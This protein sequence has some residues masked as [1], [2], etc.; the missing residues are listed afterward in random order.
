MGALEQLSQS[1][2]EKVSKTSAQSFPNNH[3]QV[4]EVLNV[5]LATEIVCALRYKNHYYRAKQLGSVDAAD[6]FL[7]HSNQESEHANQLADRIAQLGV[8]PNMDPEYIVRNK[9]SE[10]R[11][12][13]TVLEMIQEN[14]AAEHL[15][16]ETYR[17]LIQEIG[18]TDPTTRRLLESIL[19]TEEE[20]VEDLMGLQNEQR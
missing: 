6:E 20:H 4:A 17:Y 11:V 16:V 14:L 19:A 15:A 5:M 1:V 12:C 9:H 7:E 18:N 10:Y 2:R 13:D 3:A 8:I